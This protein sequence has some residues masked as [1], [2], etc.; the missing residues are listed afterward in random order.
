MSVTVHVHHS[1]GHSAEVLSPGPLDPDGLI[2]ADGPKG[3]A[4]LGLASR[5]CLNCASVA[6]LEPAANLPHSRVHL[7]ASDEAS[8][9]DLQTNANAGEPP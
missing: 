9:E 5:V 2:K 8:Q 6:P 7:G 1:C 4:K 3:L